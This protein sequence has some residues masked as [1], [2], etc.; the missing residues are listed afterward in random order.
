MI[1]GGIPIERVRSKPENST[2]KTSCVLVMV[3]AVKTSPVCE[4]LAKIALASSLG[5]LTIGVATLNG[6]PALFRRAA[7]VGAGPSFWF[8]L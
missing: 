4:S 3:L 8:V 5:W 1:S 2:A 6:P 7:P